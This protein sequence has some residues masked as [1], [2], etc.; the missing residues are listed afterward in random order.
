MKKTTLAALA[1]VCS[2]PMLMPSIPLMAQ[3]YSETATTDV[4]NFD[5]F[6]PVTLMKLFKTAL[7]NGRKYPTDAEFEAAGILP[8]D[9]AFIRSHVRKRPILDRS[10]RLVSKTYETRNLW[11]NLPMDIG[12]DGLAG[13][14]DGDFASDVFSMWQYTNLF[15]SWNHGFF[16]APGAWVDAAH[17]NGTDIM[18]GIMF[19]DTTG[20]D[21]SAGSGTWQSVI[22]EKNSDGSFAYVKPIINCLMYFG[23]DGINYNWEASGFDNTDVVAFHKALYKEA[24][25]QGFKSFHLGMYTNQSILTSAYANALYGNSEGQ[26]T[27]LMLNYNA[28]DFSYGMSASATAAEAATGSTDRLYAGVWIVSM[29]RGWTRLDADAQS[30]K[31]GICLWGEHGQSRFMSYNSGDDAMDTQ[32][33]YQRLLERGFSGGNR[34]PASRPTVSSSGNNWETSGSKLPL[35]TFCGV[36]EFIPERS[37]IQGNLPFST[38]FNL[39][40]GEIYTYKGKK[41]GRGWYNMANQDIVPTYRWLVYNAGTET[42]STDIQPEFSHKDSYTGGSCLSLSGAATSAGTD[43]ILYKTK[44]TAKGSAVVKVAVKNGKSGSNASNLSVIVRKEGSTNWIEV[45]YGN[46]SSEMWEEKTLD[47]SSIGSGDVIDRIGLRVKGSDSNYSLYVGKLEISDATTTTPAGVTDLVAEVKEETKSSMSLKLNWKVDGTATDRADWGLLYNDEANIDHFEVLYKNGQNGR[48]SEVGRTS[49]WATFVNDII[50]DST[51]DDPY[52]GVRSAS[53]DLKSYSDVQWLHITRADQSKLPAYDPN[54]YGTSEI[55]PSAEGTDIARVQRYVTDVT[56]TG[57]SGNL[58]YHADGPV[59]DGTQYANALDQT[60][61]VAQGQ[62]VELYI[63]CYDTSSLSKVDGL[64]WCFAGCWMDLDGNGK[65]HP[66]AMEENPTRGERLFRLGSVRAATPEFETQGI[67]H[68]FTVPTDAA[69]GPSRM[70]I[71]FADAWFEGT[72]LP[73]GKTAKGFTIDFSVNITG[74]NASRQPEA[75]GRDTGTADEP[76][77]LKNASGIESAPSTTSETVING[78]LLRFN[79]VDKAWVYTTDGKLVNF[80]KDAESSATGL[81]PGTY[82]VKMQYQNVIRSQKVV[83]K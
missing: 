50:F 71:V 40:N 54:T 4:Y 79:N 66:D 16:Q 9:I 67:T 33:N 6:S 45:P 58:N 70:R 14:P 2:G 30:H 25:A 12:Q 69:T 63:K 42:V 1:L 21:M 22:S 11:C 7:D 10:D 83:I 8:G 81:F 23:A 48:V 35:S 43:I 72:F 57:A 46:V 52:I 34:N 31:V 61:T 29:D 39:G 24:E 20:G 64:R 75:D 53:K 13:Y 82:V 26:T 76:E 41:T 73:T 80:V 18:S 77:G 56:T 28:G 68:K 17:K 37:A 36:A 27:D 38:H 3:T 5:K 62:E 74:S 78:N 60:L 59:S 47:M 32:A 51:D 19:F 55:D 49:Q 15:G 65:F 44:L